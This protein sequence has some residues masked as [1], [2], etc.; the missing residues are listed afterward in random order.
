MCNSLRRRAE[1]VFGRDRYTATLQRSKNVV[2][3][4]R[5]MRNMQIYVASLQMMTYAQVRA[6]AR[7]AVFTP[8]TLITRR[9]P[10]SCHSGSNHVAECAAEVCPRE[11]LM[12]APRFW[13]LLH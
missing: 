10:S 4:P 11:A 8:I 3:F 7:V 6:P 1:R 13:C 12:H 5:N 2:N 9:G